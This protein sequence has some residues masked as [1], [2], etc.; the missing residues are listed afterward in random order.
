M[1]LNIDVHSDIDTKVIKNLFSLL[2]SP[3]SGM[4][5]AGG[6]MEIDVFI[7]I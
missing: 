4:A 1:L 7:I 3:L 2:S 6:K 5:G